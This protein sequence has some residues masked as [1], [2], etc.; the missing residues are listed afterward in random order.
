MSA[1]LRY[2]ASDLNGLARGKRVPDSDLLKLPEGAARMP[3]SALC[4][5][6]WG[7]DIDASPLVFD[8][9]DADGVLLPTR[10]IP[11]PMLWLKGDAR[12]MPMAMHHDDLRP[13]AIDP[14][15]A[16]SSVL[17]RFADRGLHVVAATE[18]E[19]YLLDDS[20]KQVRPPRL[21]GH[22]RRLRAEDILSLDTLDAYD[23]YFTDLYAGAEAMGLMPQ[24]S[25]AE[26]G[27]GQFEVN[28]LHTDAMDAAEQAW[29]FKMLT[30]GT[31]RAHGMA[32]S[33]AA[34]P[35]ADQAGNG[36]HMHVS[37][38]DSQGK[39]IFDDG[40]KSGTP[41][42]QH[43]VA[44]CLAALPGSTAILMP[45]AGSFDRIV[46]G[47]HAPTGLGWGYDNRTCAIRI[48]GGA[49]AARRIEH[50]VAGGDVNPFLTMAAILGGILIGL[51]DAATP[52]PAITG[53]AYA[54]DLEQMP[55]TW[56]AAVDTFAADPY[57]A[58]IFSPELIDAFT[59]TKRQE[60]VKSAEHDPG[61]LAHFAL[62]RV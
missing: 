44:G 20:K 3:Y 47:A 52:P 9:G 56:Q 61:D 53:N 24:A 39:N 31:A 36:M 7:A 35:F 51:E 22:A 29:A 58:R 37:V 16:L 19:F 50:R 59:R 18:L 43:A 10:D 45:H 55:A 12:L 17:K 14:R 6:L 40:T 25:I 8:S 57:M 60:M 30:R 26:S 48:P 1:G 23:N 34:K 33:F 38:L 41:A 15:H 54:H 46:D 13:F 11:M 62:C 2:A 49:P 42:L 5:D 28:L 4:V 32:A 27:V 21:P